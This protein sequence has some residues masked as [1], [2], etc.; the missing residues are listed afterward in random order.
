MK[1]KRSK[2]LSIIMKH[3]E[4]VRRGEMEVAR[5]LL[6]LLLRGNIKLGYGDTEYDAE[7]I[8]EKLGCVITYSRPRYV[9]TA[10]DFGWA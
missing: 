8:L 6:R 5:I 7:R 4:L 3:R 2:R 9:A 1:V 10:H